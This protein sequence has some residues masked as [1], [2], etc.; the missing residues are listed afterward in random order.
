[1][2]TGNWGEW[3]EAYAF[4]KLLAEGELAEADAELKP[5]PAKMRIIDILRDD[6]SGI[7]LFKTKEEFYDSSAGLVSRTEI[8]HALRTFPRPTGSLN[9]G[10]FP[11]PHI[12]SLL[13]RL[14]IKSIK[15]S[16]GEKVDLKAHIANATTGEDTLFGYS[17]KSE[18]GGAATLMNSSTHTLFQYR[19]ATDLPGAQ[20]LAAQ[21][22]KSKVRQLFQGFES[23]GIK[24]EPVGARSEKFRSNLEFF[25][26]DLHLLLG[27]ML[28]TYFQGKGKRLSALLP[29]ATLNQSASQQTEYKVGQFLRAIALGMTPGRPW[30][31]N[32][33]AYGGYIIVKPDG[34]LLS[35]SA[36]NE[37]SF[38]EYLLARAYFDTPGVSRHKFGTLYAIDGEPY[39]DLSM[40][41]RFEQKV[42]N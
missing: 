42:D 22:A 37:D 18:V 35:L 7:K 5:K 16:S 41:I 34:S 28:L 9:K 27:R 19:L 10:A 32:L 21:H 15:A 31:A 11:I 39:I 33:K 36:S 4:L 23:A 24:V 38:R 13:S 30:Q 40:Q 2:L 3:S 6:S 20:E 17:I 25:D 26:D 12:E 29:E 8:I 1:M 14:G